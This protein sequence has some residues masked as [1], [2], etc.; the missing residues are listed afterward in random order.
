MFV[1]E[2]VH[3]FSNSYEYNEDEDK[4]SKQLH[5]WSVSPFVQNLYQYIGLLLFG[6]SLNQ[7]LTDATKFAV[8]RLR[9]H[10]MDVSVVARV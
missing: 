9:P 2:L 1:V 8:G 10:F 4:E 6:M 7:F 5:N 3:R